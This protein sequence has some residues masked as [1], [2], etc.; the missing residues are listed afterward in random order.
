MNDALILASELEQL[1]AVE[2][3]VGCPNART[4]IARFPD[5]QDA[6]RLAAQYPHH[7]LYRHEQKHPGLD[8][9]RQAAQ[10]L[11]GR[12]AS[13]SRATGQAR[14]TVTPAE[15]T[16]IRAQLAALQARLET[17]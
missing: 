12:R 3:R 11:R 14:M 8:Q 13:A 16:K 2:W 15:M 9:M 17:T 10:A 7:T 1:D 4:Y 6:E 5:K